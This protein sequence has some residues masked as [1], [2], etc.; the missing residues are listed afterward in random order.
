M[1][2]RKERKAWRMAAAEG[3]PNPLVGQSPQPI[4]GEVSPRL[5]AECSCRGGILSCG[6]DRSVIGQGF[7]WRSSW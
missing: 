6:T 3:D 4:A 7:A 5:S 1:Q 2:S